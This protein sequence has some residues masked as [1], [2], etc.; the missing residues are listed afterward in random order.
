MQ[1]GNCRYWLQ[2]MGNPGPECVGF[3]WEDADKKL[4]TYC[5]VLWEKRDEEPCEP[6][7]AT[8]VTSPTARASATD[9]SAT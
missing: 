4:A 9:S 8:S 2:F 6:S 3:A 5:C 1:C 7:P